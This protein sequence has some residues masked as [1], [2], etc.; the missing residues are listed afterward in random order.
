M[1][2]DFKKKVQAFKNKVPKDVVDD[3]V[4]KKALV[5]LEKT[6]KK[7]GSDYAAKM[8]KFLLALA[9][10]KKKVAKDKD[11]EGKKAVEEME[12]AAKIDK[13]KRLSF[14][15]KSTSP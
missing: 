5:E 15:D 12:K 1:A 7:S 3:A 11:K 4:M 8:D 10:A 9:K 13:K 14:T 6:I 2:D